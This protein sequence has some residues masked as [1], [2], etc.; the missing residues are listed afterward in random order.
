ML[1]SHSLKIIS[2]L[3]TTVVEDC[4]GD[5]NNDAHQSNL[6]DLKVKY[7][8]VLHSDKIQL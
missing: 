8:D 6:V 2:K 5:R 1:E 3:I 4:V 7:A